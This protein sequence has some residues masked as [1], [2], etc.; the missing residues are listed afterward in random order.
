MQEKPSV[1]L[2]PEEAMEY[3]NY[4]RQKKISEIMSAMRR[5]ESTLSEKEDVVKLLERGARLRQI[6]VRTTPTK[7][8]QY[9]DLL[10]NSPLQIDCIVGGNG[11]TFPKA[12]AYESKLAR[13][14][15][16][17]ELTLILTPSLVASCRYTE[18]R[19]EIKRVKKAAGKTLLKV[20]V[21][22]SYPQATLSRLARL[23]SECGADYFS[24]PYFAGCERLQAELLRG[25][26]LEISG[27]DNLPLFQQ[28]AGAGIGRILVSRV[29]ELYGEWL[30]EAEKI[31]VE[32]QLQAPTAPLKKTEATKPI[33]LPTAQSK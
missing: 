24:L 3:C 4:K 31:T 2:T 30:K 13:R 23:A 33:L 27:V 19:R 10:Q 6:S 11:E 9:R 17:K 29:W 8:L 25:C 20:R 7:L 16:A 21:E 12:K 1:T 22:G 26:L 32:A 28:M 14:M 15:G 5:S 18:I